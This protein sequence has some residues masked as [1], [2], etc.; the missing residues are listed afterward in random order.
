MQQT[1]RKPLVP[2]TNYSTGAPTLSSP[3][4]RGPDPAEKPFS[5]KD[6]RTR[7]IGKAKYKMDKNLATGISTHIA[8]RAPIR[9]PNMKN[10]PKSKMENLPCPQKVAYPLIF[11]HRPASASPQC[12]DASMPW[13]LDAS[14]PFRK[15]KANVNI[16]NIAKSA[17]TC[18]S[19][20]RK[21][22]RPTTALPVR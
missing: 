14:T 13:C 2:N 21:T 19:I 22:C 15:N 12:L 10:K 17:A 3:H 7:Y 9:N 20:P 8:I 5:K 11:G 16:G 1:P 6:R 18:T 4:A